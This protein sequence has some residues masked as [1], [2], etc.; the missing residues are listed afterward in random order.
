MQ[1]YQN[2]LVLVFSLVVSNGEVI[3][4]QEGELDTRYNTSDEMSGSEDEDFLMKPK[5]MTPIQRV[6]RFLKSSKFIG[7]TSASATALL[8]AAYLYTRNQQRVR[9]DVSTNGNTGPDYFYVRDSVNAVKKEQ[10]ATLI[11]EQRAKLKKITGSLKTA[12]DTRSEQLT[13][14]LVGTS[15]ASSSVNDYQG[16]HPVGGLV[17]QDKIFERVA[18]IIQ[19]ID[20]LSTESFLTQQR[21]GDALREDRMMSGTIDFQGKKTVIPYKLLYKTNFLQKR[22]LQELR[23]HG[24][25]F[26]LKETKLKNLL[27]VDY[28]FVIQFTPFR[29]S[30]SVVL[31]ITNPYCYKKMQE[32]YRAAGWQGENNSLV[33]NVERVLIDEQIIQAIGGRDKHITVPVQKLALR[34]K[35]SSSEV[36]INDRTAIVLCE[37]IGALQ[38]LTADKYRAGDM[39][40]MHKLLTCVDTPDMHHENLQY[41]SKTDKIYC[42]DAEK[43]QAQSDL[44]FSQKVSILHYFNIVPFFEL[45][46]QQAFSDHT[47]TDIQKLQLLYMVWYLGDAAKE[48]FCSQHINIHGQWNADSLG[49]NT[50]MIAWLDLF[51]KKDGRGF[52]DPRLETAFYA[53]EV[54]QGFGNT[55]IYLLQELINVNAISIAQANQAKRFGEWKLLWRDI[56]PQ[57]EYPLPLIFSDITAAE[58]KWDKNL[59]LRYYLGYVCKSFS[60]EV[61]LPLG[62]LDA[63]CKANKITAER[64]NELRDQKPWK[65]TCGGS[66]PRRVIPLQEDIYTVA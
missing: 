36:R 52:N 6:K 38:T 51:L 62:V 12:L 10:M 56:P 25:A 61:Y 7:V 24:F 45:D 44:P 40:L 21:E 37:Y 16:T 50:A 47:L 63:L 31:K 54:K 17:G 55:N 2:Y 29:A 27:E 11:T 15:T 58:Q 41:S 5:R 34:K 32:K 18:G 33:R 30:Q 13:A 35:T 60:K 39:L 65:D 26:S 3:F 1:N 9:D 20:I 46:I 23:R 59:R 8:V 22:I 28:T 66:D 64:A 14:F 49:N 42:I 43:V 57:L 4:S 48:K 19:Q 53:S